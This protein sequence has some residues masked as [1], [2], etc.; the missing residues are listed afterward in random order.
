MA[1]AA[2]P[3]VGEKQALRFCLLKHEREIPANSISGRGFFNAYYSNGVNL[4]I[5]FYADIVG[6]SSAYI[7]TSFSYAVK[8]KGA[9]QAA[10]SGDSGLTLHIDE[11]VRVSLPPSAFG[12]SQPKVGDD[13]EW[14]IVSAKGIRLVDR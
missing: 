12:R 1:K 5:G 9:E 13:V 11:T 4:G 2:T 3:L 6:V 8:A 10:F 7:V 14:H